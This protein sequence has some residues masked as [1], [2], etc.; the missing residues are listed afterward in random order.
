[1]NRA[2]TLIAVQGTENS[3]RDSRVMAVRTLLEKKKV[4]TKELTGKAREQALRDF[5]SGGWHR[6]AEVD[7]LS[8]EEAGIIAAR[9]V[10]RLQDKVPLSEEKSKALQ[11]AIAGALRRHFIRNPDKLDETPQSQRKD[12]LLKVAR[13]HLD[14][15]GVAALEEVLASGLRPQAN[16]K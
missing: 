9:L 15:K 16:E 8:E 1:M 6:G 7:R 3:T 4:K 10:R 13:E 12:E 14:E 5:Q 2:G 11:S